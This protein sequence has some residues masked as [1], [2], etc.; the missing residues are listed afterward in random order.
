MSKRTPATLRSKPIPPQRIETSVFGRIGLTPVINAAGKLTALGGS[1]QS[2]VVA[3]AQAQAARA[4]VDLQALRDV[5]GQ[6]I[7]K[8]TGAEAACV[9]PGAAAGIAI[10]TAACI[11]GSRIE[12]ILLIPDSTGMAN[13][14]LLQAGHDVNFGASV[15]QMIRLGGGITQRIGWANAV[16]FELLDEALT[17]STDIA[18]FMYVQSH[19]AVQE[20]MIPLDAC[21]AA[22]HRR[23]IPVIVDA[24]AEDDLRRYIAQGAD[25]VTYSGGKAFGGPTSGFIAG[26]RDLVE[27]C[28]LQQRGIARTMKVGKEQ[29]AG[30]LAALT[31]YVG[32]DDAAIDAARNKLIANLQ[33][34]LADVT[35]LATH[36]KAD[37]AGRAIHRLAL[38]RSDGGDI[39]ELVRF[40]ARGTPSIRVREH[41][42]D[43]GIALID[44]REM[45]APQSALVAKQVRAF[46]A[47]LRTA[48]NALAAGAIESTS[49]SKSKTKLPGKGNKTN[50]KGAA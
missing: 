13:R 38:R 16:P 26:R 47:M 12:R 17:D 40:L 31:D 32:R 46:F 8:W 27:A 9:T 35:G 48:K 18:A 4:H 14:V 39:R 42:L 44:P 37:E 5:A 36:L 23:A 24:A 30:L 25:L 7:A 33:A 19:H 50:R 2:E 28:E 49:K 20:R 10:A 15:T 3:E 21:I 6:H 43:D 45:S 1:A 41:H 29:I 34:E 22:C 11:T